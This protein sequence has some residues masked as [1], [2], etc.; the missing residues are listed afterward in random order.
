MK[1]FAQIASEHKPHAS[2]NNYQIDS[3]AKRDFKQVSKS[4]SI[5]INGDLTL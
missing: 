5:Q 3:V 2:L 4:S 1:E